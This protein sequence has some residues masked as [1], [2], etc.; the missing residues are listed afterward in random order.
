MMDHELMVALAGNIGAIAIGIGYLARRVTN[1]ERKINN[2][3]SESVARLDE[4]LEM[5][6]QQCPNNPGNKEKIDAMQG[7]R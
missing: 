7:K 5:M 1:L 6:W 3:M 2:G 4:R